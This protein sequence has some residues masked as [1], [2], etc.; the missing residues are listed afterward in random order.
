MRVGA[1]QAGRKGG[2]RALFA[3]LALLAGVATVAVSSAS[4][5]AVGLLKVR[6]GGDAEQTRIVIDLDQAA[7]GKMMSDGADGRAVLVLTGVQ[8]AGALQGAGRGPVKS[9]V[10]DQTSAGARIQMDLGP[11]ARIRRRFLLPPADGID[12]YRYVIDVASPAPVSSPALAAPPNRVALTK[13]VTPVALQ[14]RPAITP[15]KT[16]LAI[17]Q[18]LSLKKVIVIDAGHGGHDPG[19]Q[20]ARGY[21]KDLNLAAA[22][23]LKARL[24]RSGKYKVVMTRDDDV[25]VAL[26]SRPRRTCSSRYTPIPGQTPRSAA[27]ASIPSPTRPPT[28]R[29]GS[30]AVTTG[31]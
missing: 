13:A 3:A 22:K 9:W 4:R 5:A 1:I 30:S 25:Y 20:G 26:D 7:S 2:K 24:E 21:E 6:M 12:H 11:D 16:A 23:A 28:G 29:P 31:S 17:K 19:A 18:P 10:V 8:S 14:L 15:T 27:P